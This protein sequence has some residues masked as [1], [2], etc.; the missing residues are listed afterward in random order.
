MWADPNKHNG[1]KGM[2]KLFIAATAAIF[3][4]AAIVGCAR[5]DKNTEVD[6]S[7]DVVV[8]ENKEVSE[9]A[10]KIE[11][12]VQSAE[13]NASADS[14]A[15]L[16]A[17]KENIG[18][19]EKTILDKE[20]LV[21][22]WRSEYVYNGSDFIAIIEYHEDDTYLEVIFKDGAFRS[23]EEGI[24]NFNN[25]SVKNEVGDDG[26]KYTRY[27][28]ENGELENGGRYFKKVK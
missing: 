12:N 16:L 21:G 8:S 15:E 10:E 6:K 7:S 5:N 22:I 11:E 14:F 23:T 17:A 27:E 28:L 1:E 25:H 19:P 2:K 24:Y 4:C 3:F 18:D 20:Y 26:M 9:E 13:E